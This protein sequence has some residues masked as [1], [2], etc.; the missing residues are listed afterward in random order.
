MNCLMY[1]LPWFSQLYASF[2]GD[3]NYGDSMV[4]QEEGPPNRPNRSSRDT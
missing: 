3:F 2:G 4:P 1:S